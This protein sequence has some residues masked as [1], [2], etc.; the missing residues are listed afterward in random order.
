[1]A[2]FSSQSIVPVITTL[3]YTKT[4]LIH[5]IH[6]VKDILKCLLNYDLFVFNESENR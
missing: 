5:I 4:L 3:S 1:M 2:H 6:V